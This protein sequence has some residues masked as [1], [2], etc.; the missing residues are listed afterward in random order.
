[1]SRLSA[2]LIA[3]AVIEQA[4]Q[5][6]AGR[7]AELHPYLGPLISFV[8]AALLSLSQGITP[9]I[10]RQAVALPPALL[11]TAQVLLGVAIGWLGLLLAT[12]LTAVVVVLVRELYVG[13]ARER[14]VATPRDRLAPRL[15]EARVTGRG[16]G[17]PRPVASRHGADGRR[18]RVTGPPLPTWLDALEARAAR[19]GGAQ[20]RGRLTEGTVGDS[21][22]LV[23]VAV[24]TGVAAALAGL[25]DLWHR[26]RRESAL[27][28]GVLDAL[29]KEEELTGTEVLARV[30][31]PFW[32]G[33]AATV[34]I[35]GP[36]MNP[37]ARAT[38]LRVARTAAA[39][40]Q[41]DA[42]VHDGILLDGRHRAVW[43]NFRPWSPHA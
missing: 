34:L 38:A 32:H 8:P 17:V 24:G 7:P 19:R 11:I 40:V 20:R 2:W 26:R 41:R 29:T 9:L 10:Q 36:A 4:A 42:I 12:P 31:V 16:C 6:G 28:R 21:S 43:A 14:A 33:S 18:G 1:V 23:T 30:R 39:S 15:R 27:L 37:D 3:P 22:F 13:D 35:T 5:R 25:V